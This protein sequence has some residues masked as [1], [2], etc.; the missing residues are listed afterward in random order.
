MTINLIGYWKNQEPAGR[1]LITGLDNQVKTQTPANNTSQLPRIIA[2]P[3]ECTLPF[4]LSSTL[5]P[6]RLS[7]VSLCQ[8][9]YPYNGFF[10]LFP[11][12]KKT[13]SREWGGKFTWVYEE[14]WF[15]LEGW[16]YILNKISMEAFG[17]KL[18]F[19]LCEDFSMD[20]WHPWPPR[21]ML[22]V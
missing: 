22:I 4:S 7:P 6:Y 13:K 21:L 10:H 12:K 18:G 20:C 17:W 5:V 14:R 15:P 19:Q 11:S 3:P 1:L 16:T 8:I 9:L 2:T